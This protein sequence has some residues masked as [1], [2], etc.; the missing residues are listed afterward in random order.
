MNSEKK[1]VRVQDNFIK[2]KKPI[3][4]FSKP[5]IVIIEKDRNVAKDNKMIEI[6]N[7]FF[8]NIV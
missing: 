7:S 5:C 6:F 1:N 8:S 3:P 2:S 4:I